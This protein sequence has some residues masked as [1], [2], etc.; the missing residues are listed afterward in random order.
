MGHDA[1]VEPLLVLE[2]VKPNI[3]A[4]N[5]DAIAVTSANAMRA[6]E[7]LP[8]IDALLGVSVFAVGARTAEA[9]RAAR[10][11]KVTYSKGDVADLAKLLAETLKPGSLVLHLAGEHRA[12]EFSVLLAPA[13]IEAV[14]LVLY[15]MK[16]VASFSKA[17]AEAIGKGSVNAVIHYSPRSAAVFVTLMQRAGLEKQ[18]P[19]IRH[20]CLSRAVA[21]PLQAAGGKCEIAARPE[22]KALLAL[23]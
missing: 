13:G 7:N 18:V 22:E 21:E 4:G 17:A 9:A 23:V 8:G 10:F 2:R 16:A 15:R 20:L 19:V 6:A 1:L 3:P 5:F 11:D 14:T 12:K